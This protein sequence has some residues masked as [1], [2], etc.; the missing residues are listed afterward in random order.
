MH[1]LNLTPFISK[2][3]HFPRIRLVRHTIE[4][5]Y[6]FLKLFLHNLS[7]LSNHVL[8]FHLNHTPNCKFLYLTFLQKLLYIE[9]FKTETKFKKTFKF[10]RLDIQ[11]MQ[12]LDTEIISHLKYI[13]NFID[14]QIKNPQSDYDWRIFIF[15]MVKR[16][17]LLLIFHIYNSKCPFLLKFLM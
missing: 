7:V 16:T 11:D 2:L 12:F 3:P 5:I 4:G 13:N 1:C 17:I 14:E 15:S 9:H 8:C 10:F 6:C